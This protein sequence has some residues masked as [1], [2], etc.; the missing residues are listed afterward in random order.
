MNK[1][2]TWE[3]LFSSDEFNYTF[4]E[5]NDFLDEIYKVKTV[6]PERQNVFRA[7]EL[8]PLDKVK[9]IILGQDP[10]HEKGQAHGLAFSVPTGVKLPPSLVNI[11]KEIENDTGEKM[12]KNGDLTYLAKQGVL[13]LNTNLTVEEGKP[14]SHSY[15]FYRHF[16]YKVMSY[17]D[18]LDK[19]LVY[20]LWGKSAQKF[21]KPLQNPRQLVLMANHPSP[22][23]ANRGGFF[24]THL[25]S[26]CNDFLIKNN[27]T[28]IKWSNNN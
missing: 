5:I 16:I 26:K 12:I 22:L 19:P 13:L 3:E 20:I 9:V 11:F 21:A 17:L 23:S 24:N 28:P 15:Y 10:Y 25:F 6:Y 2:N 4:K 27:E 14:L 18:S 1:F 8:C 7:F